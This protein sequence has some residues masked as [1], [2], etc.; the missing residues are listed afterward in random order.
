METATTSP[1]K[2]TY[3]PWVTPRSLDAW[4]P[5]VTTLPTFPRLRSALDEYIAVACRPLAGL[6]PSERPVLGDHVVRYV[7]AGT[8]ARWRM[9][10]ALD[11]LLS[12]E[13][14]G[15]LGLVE[16]TQSWLPDIRARAGSVFAPDYVGCLEMGLRLH[17]RTVRHL[18]ASAKRPQ[19][20]PAE[21]LDRIGSFYELQHAGM[22]LDLCATTVLWYL[23]S[24]PSAG[25]AAIPEELCFL[26]KEY[27]VAHA[28]RARLV[29]PTV[30][31]SGKGGPLSR[32]TRT[33]MP[34]AEDRRWDRQY[35]EL[36]LRGLRRLLDKVA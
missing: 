10:L 32:S 15:F 36:A 1:P 3:S 9:V 27:G 21:L 8:D 30:A 28:A 2:V 11:E 6:S 4:Q 5:P 22:C 7:M 18:V 33:A 16:D 12:D 23:D 13:P 17:V 20:A 35:A 14:R 29:F 26:V 34:T 19:Q 31:R 24:G 25:T